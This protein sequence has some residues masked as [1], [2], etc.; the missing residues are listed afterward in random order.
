MIRLLLGSDVLAKDKEIQAIKKSVLHHKD[1][2]HFDFEKIDAHKL[3]PADL[4]KALVALPVVSEVRLVH[5]QNADKLTDHHGTVIA[6]VMKSNADHLII[7][8]DSLKEE[9]KISL[10]KGSKAKRFD[11]PA[12]KQNVFNVTNAIAAH[13]PQEALKML[14]QV[15][16]GGDH[17][18][19][20]MGGLLW[21]WGKQ[22]KRLTAD[23]YKQ[24]LL[25]LQ[26]A[27]FHI[28]RSR[29]QPEQAMEVAVTKLCL[30]GV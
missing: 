27:D 14:S 26:E 17:P 9:L 18:L 22:K 16:E 29:L 30:L 3:H 23:H 5:V 20:I 21:F 6:D 12:L 10:A 15:I 13:N 2:L 4:K 25:V 7:I 11:V 8:L 19:Q 1:A 24:G 28:K